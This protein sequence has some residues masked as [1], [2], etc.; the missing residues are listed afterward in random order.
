MLA[1]ELLELIERIHFIPSGQVSWQEALAEMSRIMGARLA[2]FLVYDLY[3]LEVLDYEYDD[4]PADW[5]DA[6]RQHYVKLDRR[7]HFARANPRQR[8]S[9]TD[10]GSQ[11]QLI[12]C[13]LTEGR[14]FR[15]NPCIDLTV[16]GP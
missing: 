15:M 16:I 6:Y 7:M 9:K 1:D 3:E 13:T 5:F 4:C 10:A 8:F 14:D 2:T 12:R 11:S